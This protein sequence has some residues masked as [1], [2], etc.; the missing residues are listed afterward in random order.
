MEP[1]TKSKMSEEQLQFLADTCPAVYRAYLDIQLQQT[2]FDYIRAI[3]IF[4]VECVYSLNR[5]IEQYLE[6]RNKL[7]LIPFGTECLRLRY[8]EISDSIRGYQAG[9]DR[10]RLQIDIDRTLSFTYDMI[11]SML[12]EMNILTHM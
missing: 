5:Q 12:H 4:H 11:S 2:E 7:K 3:G 6:L 10:V 9:S 8:E 1:I